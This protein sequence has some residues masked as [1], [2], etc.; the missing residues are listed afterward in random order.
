MDGNNNELKFDSLDFTLKQS[1]DVGV[2]GMGKS[3]G[4]SD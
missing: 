4:S 2:S 1:R 3:E